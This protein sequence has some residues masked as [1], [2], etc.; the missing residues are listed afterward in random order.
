MSDNNVRTVS[1]VMNEDKQTIKGLL[2]LLSVVVY[3]SAIIYAEVHGFSMLSKG[4]N[5]DYLVFAMVGMIALGITAFALPAGLIF[6]FY[7]ANQRLAA[8]LFYVLDFGLL[9]AN[10]AIDFAIQA[11]GA[12]PSWGMIYLSWVLPITPVITGVGWAIIWHFDP[13]VDEKVYVNRIKAAARKYVIL[14]AAKKAEESC[15]ELDL[16]GS[17]LF[18]EII[19]GV[20]GKVPDKKPKQLPMP[21][22][23]MDFARQ[24][25]VDVVAKDVTEQREKVQ[26]VPQMVQQKQQRGN[27]SRPPQRR[28]QHQNRKR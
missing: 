18:K 19:G 9:C 22:P 23:K 6:W 26:P 24:F 20:I 13:S 17:D 28:P 25:P 4:V 2:I 5:A 21:Q 11:D 1:D 15:E 12:L 10:A 27:N 8:L 16:S 14:Q 3:A 7:G